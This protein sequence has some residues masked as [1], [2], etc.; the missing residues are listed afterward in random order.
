M[1][2]GA[3]HITRLAFHSLSGGNMLL[4]TDL[5]SP[6]LKPIGRSVWIFRHQ[7]RQYDS[8]HFSEIFDFFIKRSTPYIR[9]KTADIMM[10]NAMI[11]FM[12]ITFPG[13]LFA[14]SVAILRFVYECIL[15]EMWFVLFS[16]EYTPREPDY[17][18]VLKPSKM[19]KI[20]LIKIDY[21]RSPSILI[22]LSQQ[23]L[24]ELKGV[25]KSI[26]VDF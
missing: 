20:K 7:K 24:L 16:W 3:K 21:I 15:N 25:V 11:H 2:T 18:F 4:Y 19:R 10:N 5:P 26:S 6:F 22:S 8:H 9:R 14:G 12:I 1:V 23:V 17:G 13:D